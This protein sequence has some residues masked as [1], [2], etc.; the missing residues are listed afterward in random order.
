MLL[1][2]ILIFYICNLQI[3][4]RESNIAVVSIKNF[5]HILL[6]QILCYIQ[7]DCEASLGNIYTVRLNLRYRYNIQLNKS[8]LETALNIELND[9]MFD[10]ILG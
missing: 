10:M 3:Y 6:I 1:F 8:N 5:P 7:N 2:Y 9:R 4:T